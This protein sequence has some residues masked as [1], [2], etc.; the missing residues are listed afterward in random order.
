MVF[1][2][3]VAGD[4]LEPTTSGLRVRIYAKNGYEYTITIE[5]NR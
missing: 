3:L 4:G 2:Y 1:V 5:D